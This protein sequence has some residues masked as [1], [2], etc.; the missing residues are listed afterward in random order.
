MAEEVCADDDGRKPGDHRA[1]AHRNVEE[2][3]LLAHDRAR[4]RNQRIRNNQTKDFDRALV[5]AERCDDGR[6]VA[7]CAQEVAALRP[8][9]EVKENFRNQR[10]Q[11]DDDERGVGGNRLGQRLREGVAEERIAAKEG[12][13][14]LFW[15]MCRLMEY[16][17]VM[18]M[19]PLSKSRTR[20][21]T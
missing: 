17:P 8:Q 14:A 15:A 12:R 6:V 9:E 21:L 3:L 13:F 7:R 18:V 5:A 4:E 11:E 2:T 10:N 20:H 1:G 16:S 19:M